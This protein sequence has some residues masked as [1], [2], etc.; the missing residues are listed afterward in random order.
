LVAALTSHC[1]ECQRERSIEVVLHADDNFESLNPE[2]ALCLYRVA[3]EALR[4]V[5]THADARRAVLRLTRTDNHAELT[6]TDDGKGF[7]RGLPRGGG[8]GLGLFSINERIRLAG[9]TVDVLTAPD[10]GTTIRVRIPL[11]TTAGPIREVPDSER[12][13]G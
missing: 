2:A 11:A 1:A 13:F 10:R 7:D 8:N 12:A 6:V 4:N 5:V 9:G 3:Q